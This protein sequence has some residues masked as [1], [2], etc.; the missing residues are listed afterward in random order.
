VHAP[1]IQ[2]EVMSRNRNF[3]FANNIFVGSDSVVHGPSSGEKFVHNIWWSAGGRIFFRGYNSLSEWSAATGQ[4]KL[5]GEPRGRQIDPKLKGPFLT[6]LT[7]PYQLNLLTGYSLMP[8]SPVK[9]SILDLTTLQ[10]PIAPHDFFGN[11]VSQQSNPGVQQ[12]KRN[13]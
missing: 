5:D 3:L 1:A 6:N 7:D 8:G 11:P 4:E 2:L 12:L 13:Q 10:I 9:N